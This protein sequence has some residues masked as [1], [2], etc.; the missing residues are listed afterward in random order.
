[1]EAA[2]LVRI[3]ERIDSA[4]LLFKVRVMTNEL[5]QRQFGSDPPSDRSTTPVS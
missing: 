4:A 1:M 5:R 3:R 2:D